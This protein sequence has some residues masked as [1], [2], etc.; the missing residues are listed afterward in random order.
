MIRPVNL[1]IAVSLLG[2]S[3]SA[4]AQTDSHFDDSPAKTLFHR[5]SWAHGYIHGYE[6][7]FHS[8]NLD[9]HLARQIRDP[10]AVKEYKL[11]KHAFHKEFGNRSEF[12]KGYESGFE[13][14][15]VD[16]VTGKDFRAAGE[17]QLISED[18]NGL[19]EPDAKHAAY[20]DTMLGSGYATGRRIGLNDARARSESS[21]GKAQ[22]PEQVNAAQLCGAYRMGYRW[23]Y[24]DGYSNQRPDAA[25]QRASK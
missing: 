5:S 1:L 19:G 22:C 8:G 15:Y 12:E 21:A 2:F 9:L 7:G 16:G 6:A 14:G 18:L 10:H 23:G 24:T 4:I 20:F 11:A 13:V 3:L 17:A 25:T